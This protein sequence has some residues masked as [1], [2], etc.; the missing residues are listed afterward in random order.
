[1]SALVDQFYEQRW[2]RST[3]GFSLAVT[4]PVAVQR[5]QVSPASTAAQAR[6]VGPFLERVQQLT[7][8]RSNW[9]GRGSAA[10][11]SDAL[12]FAATI[13]QQIM[14]PQALSPDVVPLGH[15]GIQLVWNTAR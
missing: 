14:P 13:L 7:A 9:D 3:S 1:M 6:W 15:G 12:S 11:R 8:L 4:D 5:P 2:K 10:V